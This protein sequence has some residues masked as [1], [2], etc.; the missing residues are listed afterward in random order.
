MQTGSGVPIVPSTS[1]LLVTR[2]VVTDTRGMLSTV[3]SVVIGASS[4]TSII[5]YNRTPKTV[6]PY[7]SSAMSEDSVLP[8]YID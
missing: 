6:P 1:S 4:V 8:V 5:P 2:L 3:T 7:N